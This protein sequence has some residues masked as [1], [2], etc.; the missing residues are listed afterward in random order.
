MNGD[1][2]D[3]TAKQ[4]IERYSMIDPGDGIVVGVLEGRI[5]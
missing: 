5:P 2:L 4:C 1:M 3:A